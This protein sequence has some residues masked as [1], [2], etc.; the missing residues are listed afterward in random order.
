[1]S[2]DDDT[3]VTD[4]DAPEAPAER[5]PVRQLQRWNAHPRWALAARLGLGAFPALVGFGVMRLALVVSHPKGAPIPAWVW[6]GC[7]AVVG[8]LAA[9]A[10]ER[11]ARRFLPLVAFLRLSMAFPDQAPSRFAVAMRTGT[12]RQLE[13]RIEEIRSVGLDGIPEEQFGSIVLELAAALSVHD[14]LTRGHSERVRAYTDLIA[15]EMDLP[16]IDVEK[17]RWASLLHDVGKLFVP[18]EVLN[19]PGRLTSDEFDIIKQHPLHGL[20]LVMPLR[21]WLGP[22]ALVVGQ[23]HERWDG[24]GYPFGLAGTDIHL[25]ARIV[26]VAD[27]FDVM[28][29][30]RSYKAPMK[31]SDARAELTRCSGRQFDPA[32]VRAFL[33]VGLPRTS[34]LSG[35]FGLLMN[36]GSI[37]GGQILPQAA[38]AL[39]GLVVA[40]AL[41]A[42]GLAPVL[43]ARSTTDRPAAIAFTDDDGSATTITTATDPEVPVESNSSSSVGGRDTSEAPDT[44]VDRLGP[45]SNAGDPQVDSPTTGTAPGTS[46]DPSPASATSS[47][48]P[49]SGTGPSTSTPPDGDPDD[50]PTT[51]AP[52]PPSNP[53]SPSLPSVP[54]VPAT[55]LPMTGSLVLGEDSNGV[56]TVTGTGSVPVLS[57]LGVGAH[58]QVSLSAGALQEAYGSSPARWV[59]A[60]NYAPEPEYSGSDQVVVRSCRGS[61]CVDTAVT[62]SVT[63]VNDAPGVDLTNL[64]RSICGQVAAGELLAGAWDIEGDAVTLVSATRADGQAVD[65]SNLGLLGVG[66]ETLTVTVEDVHGARTSGPLTVTVTAT[67]VSWDGLTWAGSGPSIPGCEAAIDRVTWRL[68]GASVG[69][70][71]EGDFD[72][73]SAITNWLGLLVTMLSPGTHTLTAEVVFADGS[74]MPLDHTY[75]IGV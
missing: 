37:G 45:G 68:D 25:G 60:L 8:V 1:M 70:A 33:S 26:S 51:S 34:Q 58:G 72:I 62:V 23:H 42:V 7:V 21:D 47:T 24:A 39:A 20:R 73:R 11:A 28:T 56:W 27:A 40:S 55:N 64:E 71:T 61:A 35:P 38:P 54:I 67:D 69:T 36:V 29:S 31:V 75:T 74:T 10:A 30:A 46:A 44:G 13:R 9:L 17:L 32:V 66:P 18:S 22:W 43:E 2:S 48:I 53:S 15:A 50:P 14:R 16:E 12:T 5:A 4:L 49:R 3:Q 59:I 19:K 57:L 52:G 6:F 63:P 41:T 65:L